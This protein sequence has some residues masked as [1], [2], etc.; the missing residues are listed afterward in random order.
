M[1]DST[2]ILSLLGIFLGELFFVIC[3]MRGWL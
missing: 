3:L 1:K 2:V